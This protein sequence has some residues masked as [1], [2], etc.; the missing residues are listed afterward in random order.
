MSLADYIRS[1]GVRKVAVI[2]SLYPPFP[3]DVQLLWGGVEIDMEDTV[4]SLKNSG[5]EVSV[6]SFDYI[7]PVENDDPDVKRIGIYMPHLLEKSSKSMFSF[8]Y[9]EF[10]R[11][12]IFVKMWNCLRKNKPELVVIGGTFQFSLAIYFACILLRIPYVVRYDWFCP[13]N[14]KDEL[15]SLRD[16]FKCAWCIEKI[17]GIK[18]PLI[19]K[20]AAGL[21]FVPLFLLKR[22]FWNR[23]EK[24]LVV[25]GFYREVAKSFGVR[26]E[27][28]AV[29][30][31]KSELKLDSKV[32]EE[33]KR[34]YKSQGEFVLLYVG[35]LE[36]EKGVEVLLD[37]FK[38]VEEEKVK[39]LIAG[40]GRLVHLV[41]DAM[42]KDKRIT[43]LGLVPHEQIGNYYAIADSAIVPSIVPEG[44]PVVVEEAMSLNKT[45]IG[46]NMGGL[47]EILKTYERG[48]LVEERRGE[49]FAEKIR[50]I[51]KEMELKQG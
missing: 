2:T 11:P 45:I 3:D 38:E 13:T 25:S 9:K 6:I 33:L 37:A 31:P 29:I 21:Y 10:F 15:C 41:N 1:K 36:P 28:I 44:H 16:R 22:I 4:K 17:T 43:Y 14:P 34:R 24:V 50:K 35:R 5:I 18:I 46:S 39:L 19:G 23:A 49:A 47:G 12:S 40:T 20:I 26:P 8:A 42:K 51:M 32:I 48:I 7:K 27:K 30:P